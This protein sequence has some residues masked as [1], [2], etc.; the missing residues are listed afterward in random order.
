M[1]VYSKKST[2]VKIKE[3]HIYCVFTIC[4]DLNLPEI[5]SINSFTFY[6]TKMV[7]E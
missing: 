6:T 2:I 7:L 4:K 3:E 1:N 5:S